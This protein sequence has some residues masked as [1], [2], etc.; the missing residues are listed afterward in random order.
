MR[1]RTREKAGGKLLPPPPTGPTL[2]TF[3]AEYVK[4]RSPRWKPSTKATDTIYN[5][6]TILPARGHLRLGS[7]VRADIA[8]FFHEYVHPQPARREQQS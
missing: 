7:F 6:S 1:P 3:A 5:D 8:R 4:R 2:T